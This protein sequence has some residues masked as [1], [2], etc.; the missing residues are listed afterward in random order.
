LAL[1]E[2]PPRI[3]VRTIEETT[4]RGKRRVTSERRE[5]F[6]VDSIVRPLV[7]ENLA[8]DRPWNAGFV[9]LMLGSSKDRSSP[10]VKTSYEKEGLNAMSASSL[11]WDHDGET[12]VVRAVHEALRNRYGKI[13]DENR[14]NPVAMRN[15]FAGEYDRWRLAFAGAKTA[16]QF[17]Y[18]L[19]DLFSRAGNNPVLRES[20]MKVLPFLDARRWQLT[21]DLAL[22]GLASYASRGEADEPSDTEPTTDS[23]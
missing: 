5:A 23:E 12:A 1:A 8:L 9:R 4:G 21:R 3:M 13:A 19:C 17:R 2:L 7:A 22:L 16:D 15:R 6:R 14:G 11:F 18:A 20:W 10:C